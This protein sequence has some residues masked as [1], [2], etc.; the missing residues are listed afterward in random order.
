MWTNGKGINESNRNWMKEG[1]GDYNEEWM[2]GIKVGLLKDLREAGRLGAQTTSEFTAGTD[3]E[4]YKGMVNVIEQ[5]EF[6]DNLSGEWLDPG[7]VRE[8]RRVEMEEVEKHNV[9]EKLPIDECHKETGKPP[10]GRLGPP[11]QVERAPLVAPAG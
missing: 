8:A 11:P 2:R 10:K 9:Y 3:K 5:Q 7:M 6:Y 4:D 1:G